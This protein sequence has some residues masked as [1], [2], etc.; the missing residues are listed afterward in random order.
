M[1]TGWLVRLGG[2]SWAEVLV[3]RGRPGFLTEPVLGQVHC[4][5]PR[6]GEDPGGDADQFPGDRCGGRSCE[7]IFSDRCVGGAVPNAMTGRTSHAALALNTPKYRCAKTLLVRFVG[8][9]SPCSTEPDSP[10]SS[11]LPN[12]PHNETGAPAA[13]RLVYS[14]PF[15][16]VIPSSVDHFPSSS[17]SIAIVSARYQNPV[18][19]PCAASR[20]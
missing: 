6:G 16:Y 3:E 15:Y 11:H 13:A 17:A 10:K 18:P 7:T 8:T 14:A 5:A 9:P 20:S 4:S 1:L 19:V 2:L 12:P